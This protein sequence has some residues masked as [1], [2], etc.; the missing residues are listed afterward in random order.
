[1]IGKKH[2]MNM[3]SKKYNKTMIKKFKKLIQK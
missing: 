2:S 3:I 1:M